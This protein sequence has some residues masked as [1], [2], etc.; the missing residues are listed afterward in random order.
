MGALALPVGSHRNFQ[1]FLDLM[2]AN[3]CRLL[4]RFIY[5]LMKFLTMHLLSSNLYEFSKKV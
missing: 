2:K 3:A 4:P 1:I 5:M